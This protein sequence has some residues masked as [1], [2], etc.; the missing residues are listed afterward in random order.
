MYFR[1]L[2]INIPTSKSSFLS[3]FPFSSVIAGDQRLTAIL[4]SA[5]QSGPFL[6]PAAPPS[7]SSV[8]E[9]AAQPPSSSLVHSPFVFGQCPRSQVSQP[10]PQLP[11]KSVRLYDS[12]DACLPRCS[13]SHLNSSLAYH[14]FVCDFFTCVFGGVKSNGQYLVW[15][16][17]AKSTAVHLL[18][19]CIRFASSCCNLGARPMSPATKQRLE[20]RSP[21][22]EGRGGR[23]SEQS[24]SKDPPASE[25][26]ILRSDTAKLRSD[27]HSR[28]HSP[29]HNTLQALKADGR[30][31]NSSG[32]RAESPNP[33]SRSTSP[34]QKGLS[35][36]SGRTNQL[37][38]TCHK[39]RTNPM[40][41][42]SLPMSAPPRLGWTRPEKGPS[43]TRTPWTRTP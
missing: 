39:T 27:S 12:V 16:P 14:S 17:A 33:G 9:Q 11:S 20:S 4:N 43:R 15:P 37:T 38:R 26:L 42:T 19:D 32:L 36:T 30:D 34:K 3:P 5:I 35:S 10:Q 29:N 13:W 6:P 7:S 8:F 18:M 23:T 1:R 22:Q 2:T 25:A 40:T 41:R 21:K 28:S 31:R 24:K